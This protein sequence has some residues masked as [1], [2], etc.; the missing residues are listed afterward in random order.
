[1]D[2][3]ILQRCQLPQI[4]RTNEIGGQRQS[5]YTPN[6]R[7]ARRKWRRQPQSS[8]RLDSQ[9][10][11][12]REDEERGQFWKR[13]KNQR[14][15]VFEANCSKQMDSCKNTTTTFQFCQ[16]FLFP[17]GVTTIPQ[18]L[19]PWSFFSDTVHL[20]SLSFLWLVGWLVG[21]GVISKEVLVGP[22][23]P[24]DAGKGRL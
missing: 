14:G 23:I 18:R 15:G 4:A 19:P 12:D 11:G 6:S 7:A 17:W 24:G 13:K 16:M 9:C 22:E 10:S 21:H 3:H 1:M 8:C 20:L 2:E 5:S